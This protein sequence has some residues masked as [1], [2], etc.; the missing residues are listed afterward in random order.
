MCTYKLRMKD[1]NIPSNLDLKIS[2]YKIL[3]NLMYKV[4]FKNTIGWPNIFRIH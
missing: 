3:P 1:K 4:N 2:R